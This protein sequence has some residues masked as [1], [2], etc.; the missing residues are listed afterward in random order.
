MKTYFETVNQI[1]SLLAKKVETMRAEGAEWE[2]GRLLLKDGTFATHENYYKGGDFEG[3]SIALGHRVDLFHEAKE[4]KIIAGDL[5]AYPGAKAP[6]LKI[7]GGH[8]WIFEN[9]DVQ[10]LK[11]I[12][13]ALDPQP[14]AVMPALEVVG[15][16]VFL[17]KGVKVPNLAIVGKELFGA[18]NSSLQQNVGNNPALQYVNEFCD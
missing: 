1:R 5:F 9:A 8:A 17:C 10:S 11:V 2:N 7:V 4:L 16:E 13:G 3:V 18:S 6:N 15:M 12:C 14:N